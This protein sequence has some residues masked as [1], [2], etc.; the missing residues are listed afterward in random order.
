MNVVKLILDY[1]KIQKYQLNNKTNMNLI[2]EIY[3]IINKIA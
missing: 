1:I 3:N 2:N